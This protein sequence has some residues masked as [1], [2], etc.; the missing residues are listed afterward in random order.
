MIS[1]KFTDKTI[2]FGNLPTTLKNYY[3]RN[4]RGFIKFDITRR[5]I[6]VPRS[7]QQLVSD[8]VAFV[9][10]LLPD[11]FDIYI[12]LCNPKTSKYGKKHV[13]TWASTTN[14]IHEVGHAIGLSHANQ[15][16]N[17]KLQTSRDAFS[18]MTIHAPYPSLN[19]VHRDQ[20]GWFL[21]PELVEIDDSE[22]IYKLYKLSDL[23]DRTNLKVIR[24][25]KFYISYGSLK[26]KNYLVVH[27]LKVEKPK[28]FFKWSSYL[29]G[30]YNV[31]AGHGPLIEGKVYENSE[32][33]LCLKV[34]KIRNEEK[35]DFVELLIKFLPL[36]IN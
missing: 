8:S 3:E 24:K 36:Q 18:Q 13:I 28:G 16:I 30:R 7:S 19:P 2:P 34:L 22:K 23:N 31:M 6:S 20:L 32:A 17:G 12:H 14:V 21:E 11:S 25:G 35:S 1:Y 26:S 33:G 5:T 27:K 15:T 29:I 4:S 10:K 9:R